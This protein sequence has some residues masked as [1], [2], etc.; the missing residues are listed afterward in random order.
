MAESE[1]WKLIKKFCIQNSGT[2]SWYILFSAMGK[3]IETLLI[4]RLLAKIF[5]EVNDFEAL[6]KNIFFFLIVFTVEKI[7]YLASTYIN[8]RIEPQLTSFLTVEFIEAIF[9]KYET[10]HMPIDVAVTM[11]K[12]NIIRQVLEDLIYYVYKL[13]P[14]LIVLVVTVISV[15]VV[16]I[17]LGFFVLTSMI[18][19]TIILCSIPKPKDNT[20][21]KDAMYV[22]M[23]DIFRNMEIISSNEGGLPTAKRGITSRV[24]SLG[25]NRTKTGNKVG[26]NQGIGYLVSTLLYVGS[27][28]FLYKLY[29]KGEVS[30]KTF[31][32]YILTLGHLFKLAYDIS[33]YLP[34]FM[35]NI[36]VLMHNAPFINEL[37]SYKHKDGI[38]VDIPSSD[39]VFDNVTFG[40]SSSNILTNF[41][42]RIHRG[43]MLALYGTSGSGKTTFTNLVLDIL[44]PTEGDIF[45]GEYAVEQ[46]SKKSIRCHIAN[47]AQNT[48]SLLR[49]SIYSNIIYGFEDT[50]QLRAKVEAL[51]Q[52]YNL[53]RIFV[54]PNFLDLPVGK[55]G[56]TLSGGQKQIV[57]LLHAAINNKAEVIIL[58]E[59][60]SA[61]DSVSKQDIIRLIRVLNE[62]GRTIILITHDPQIKSICKSVLSFQAGRNPVPE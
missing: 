37:F 8:K 31:E 62:E 22:Y 19:L 59:P 17:K 52:E 32:A 41:D 7:L 20:R 43:D 58:D 27:I 23:E 55:G 49:I 60:T 48:T 3:A 13:I 29:K 40:F 5:T 4:P 30:T 33:Y 25:R 36:Q 38:D 15:F 11:E 54:H 46:L 18:A 56:L 61:L 51:T 16:N 24:K 21:E 47:V 2:I 26:F 6:K 50:P 12:I 45:I 44:Q 53:H 57:H 10:T 35:H 1:V 9:R 39:I 14:V 28:I 42:Y 34:D